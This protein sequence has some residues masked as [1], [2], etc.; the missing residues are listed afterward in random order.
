MHNTLIDF[1]QNSSDTYDRNKALNI[2]TEIVNNELIERIIITFQQYLIPE[3]YEVEFQI[4]Q[5]LENRSILPRLLFSSLY[6]KCRTNCWHFEQYYKLMW[7]C[8]NNISYDRFYQAWNKNKLSLFLK[9]LRQKVL[10]SLKIHTR[11]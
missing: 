7:F 5:Y 11:L 10:L 8:S 6:D 9:I 1:I 3:K 4:K 2:L